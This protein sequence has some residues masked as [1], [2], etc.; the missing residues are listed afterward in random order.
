VIDGEEK[1]LKTYRH[2]EAFGELALMYNAPRAATII[3][4]EPGKLYSLDRITFSQ[5]VKQ[6]AFKKRELY[7]NVIDKIEVF[8]SINAVEKYPISHSGSS[9]WTFS[10]KKDTKKVN[11]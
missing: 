9:S 11:T 3:C 8:S 6:A 5:V 10:R 7:K 2:G 4:K 1:Y